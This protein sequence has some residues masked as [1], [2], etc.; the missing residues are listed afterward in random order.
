MA[1]VTKPRVTTA[2]FLTVDLGPGRHELV[3]GEIVTLP[4]PEYSHGFVCLNIG[5]KLHTF[6]NQ[7]GH[8]HVAS[9]DASVDV[10]G[11]SV[12]GADVCYYSE[13]RWPRD[14]VGKEPPPCPPDLVV[15]VVSAS[16]RPRDVLDRVGQYLGAGVPMVW[17]ANPE[18]RTLAIYRADDVTPVVLAADQFLGGLP[19]LPGFRC[20]VAEFFP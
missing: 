16:D 5:V 15:E 2:E 7:T 6:G 14:R 19:E 18:P 13:A 9:N 1:T 11:D 20:R 17:V 4:P 3:R 8:G 12:R 10:G